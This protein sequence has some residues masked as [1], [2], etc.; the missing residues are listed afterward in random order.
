VVNKYISSYD[1]ATDFGADERE[2]STYCGEL[3]K[4]FNLGYEDCP[5]S[6]REGV[7]LDVIRKCDNNE[8]SVSGLHRIG[9]W[10][11]G[12]GEILQ[13]FYDSDG[14]LN[15]LFPKCWHGDRPLRY[16]GNYIISNS[17]SLERDYSLVFNH[18][19]YKKYFSGY[20]NIYE[21]GCGTGHNIAVMAEILQGKKFF[22][23]DWV[24]ESQELLSEIVRRYGWDI[25]GSHF[26]FYEPDYKLE[27]LPNSLVYTA[28]ALE[29][30]GYDFTKFLDY[31]LSKKPM[32][33]VNVECISEYYSENN[34][35]DYIA[36]K[37]HRKRNYLEGF[38]P[39]LVGL[40]N[41]NK[42]KIISTKRTG[43]GSLYHE[44]YMYIVWKIL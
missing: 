31:L 13:D 21:F 19:L 44:A 42:I 16:Q 33:C 5:Q 15:A 24:I 40:E 20:D 8:L 26:N 3:I 11:R 7:F 38:L 12:W 4:S 23:M 36:L 41:Q 39:Y 28:S 17:N 25:S 43:M 34:L 14:H 35:Y 29:Q 18:W 10:S 30:V 9:D 32:L 27:I 22:G 1:L 2:I 37:Y 6:V